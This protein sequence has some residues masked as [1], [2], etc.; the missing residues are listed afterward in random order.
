MRNF[1][2][3]RCIQ[4]NNYYWNQK[5]VNPNETL[6]ARKAS[7]KELAKKVKDVNSL[8]TSNGMAYQLVVRFKFYMAKEVVNLLKV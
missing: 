1:I 2:T 4:V 7:I 5:N 3:Q 6:L 8:L